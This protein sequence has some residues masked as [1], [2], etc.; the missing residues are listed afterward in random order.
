MAI[1]RVSARAKADLLKVADYS[2]K[3]WGYDQSL[4]YL[5]EL[6][7]CFFRISDDPLTGRA[8]DE[9]S[10]GLRRR[11]QGKH[12]VFSR[13]VLGGIRVVRV[14]HHAMQPRTNLFR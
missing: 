12:I 9:I 14:L 3:T 1:V 13:Q 6:Q 8:C 7:M 2:L 11:P 4:K 5:Y 10:L